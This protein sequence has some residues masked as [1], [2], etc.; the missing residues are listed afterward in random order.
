MEYRAR[1]AIINI[2]GVTPILILL[3][4]G[5]PVAAQ[6]SSPKNNF[7]KNV[8][9]CNGFDRTSPEPQI[10]GC[11]ALID[12]GE[13]TAAVAIAYNNRGDAYTA[14][15]EYDRAVQD[16]DQSIKLNSTNANT[17]NNRGV[18]Y[19]K[20]GEYDLAIKNLDEAIRLKPIYP[21]AFF[22]RAETYQKKNEYDRAAR[23]FDE[24]IRLDP[25]LKAVWSARCWTRA[26]LGDL[27][28]ALEDC[29]KA[30]QSEPNDAATYELA[31]VD[32]HKDGPI[33]HGYRRL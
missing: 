5:S 29:N 10:M 16:F 12:L 33:R 19:I 1:G 14:K 25:N 23:D 28:A 4:L 6:N 17:F 26:I 3:L 15:G 13:K 2:N 8:A 18:A 30:L 7:L 22:N 24:A 11:T 20:K 9:L 32:L 31:W 27:Q 21:M